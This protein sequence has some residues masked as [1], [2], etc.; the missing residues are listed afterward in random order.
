MANETVPQDWQIDSDAFGREL[1]AYLS[2]PEPEVLL[3]DEVKN[4]LESLIHRI[5]EYQKEHDP[6][7]VEEDNGWVS[8]RVPIADSSLVR[9][10]P[11]SG[12]YI[13]AKVMERLSGAKATNTSNDLAPT[14]HKLVYQEETTYDGGEPSAWSDE[15]TILFREDLG[16][17]PLFWKD[18]RSID[19]HRDESLDDKVGLEI[20]G[21]L[22]AGFRS[23]R[24]PLKAPIPLQV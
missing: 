17:V 20:L 5:I 7:G 8:A 4:K 9:G 1:D 3:S 15:V 23:V 16:D 14:N 24:Q 12:A 11:Q 22:E 13:W 19:G 2:D 10:A 6:N 21:D 18:P